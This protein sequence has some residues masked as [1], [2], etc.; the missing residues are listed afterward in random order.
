[1]CRRRLR[2]R[3]KYVSVVE[4]PQQCSD[5]QLE[6]VEGISPRGLTY[7]STEKAGYINSVPLYI[8]RV[9]TSGCNSAAALALFATASR[10]WPWRA[11]TSTCP[12]QMFRDRTRSHLAYFARCPPKAKSSRGRRNN[13]T[14]SFG[15]HARTTCILVPGPNCHTEFL[16]SSP[17]A[18]PFS[19]ACSPPPSFFFA[20]ALQSRAQR[21]RCCARVVARLPHPSGNKPRR[22]FWAKDHNKRAQHQFF[23]PPPHT[24]PIPK[25]SS[26]HLSSLH[27]LTQAQRARVYFYPL[28]SPLCHLGL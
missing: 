19:P 14:F 23:C 22:Q 4:R 13:L 26:L 10:R 7:L 15:K 8:C 3:Y 24:P 25:F 2:Q 5:Q 9:V 18:R 28:H 27:V 20:R 21:D 1:M 6:L 16:T 17:P 12:K 11:A